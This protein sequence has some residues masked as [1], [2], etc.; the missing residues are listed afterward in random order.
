VTEFGFAFWY[1]LNAPA[2]TPPAVL[3]ALQQAAR[4]ALRATPA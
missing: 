2:A 4:L 3:E 1:G